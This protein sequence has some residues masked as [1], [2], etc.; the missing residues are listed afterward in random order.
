MK[1]QPGERCVHFTP[2]LWV[3]WREA[4]IADTQTLQLRQGIAEFRSLLSTREL[5]PQTLRDWRVQS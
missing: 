3:K 5:F 4:R 2:A 1:H